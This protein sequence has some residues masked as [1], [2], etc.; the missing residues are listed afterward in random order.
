MPAG[1]NQTTSAILPFE[2]PAMERVLQPIE[3]ASGLPNAAYSNANFAAFER[4]KVLAR[5]WTCIGFGKDIPM[6]GDARPVN[7]M[8]L[9]LLMVRRRD[10]TI[11][12]FH[13][14]CSHRGAVL[15][16]ATRNAQSTFRCP[17]HAW[18][19]DL[20]GKL[21]ATPNIGGPKEHNCDGFDK[22]KHGLKE[23][24]TAL[25]WDLVFINL[26]G[27]AIAFDEFNSKLRARWGDYDMSLIRHCGADSSLQLTVNCNWKLAVE[28]YCEAYHL[29]VI[30]PGLNSYS[31]LEDHYNIN[32]EGAFAGQGSTAYTP[33]LVENGPD[34]PHF[35]G[36]PEKW[37]RAAEYA[38]LF[39]NVLL[40]IH[41][42]HYFAILLEPVAVDRTIE[43][44]EIYYVGDEAKSDSYAVTRAANLA[45]WKTV[46]DE[47]IGVVESMQRGRQ[48]PGFTGGAFSP[49]MDPPTHCFHKWLARA[50]L[51][52]IESAM[53][54]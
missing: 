8:G 54:G 3:T 42:D 16:D 5:T 34:L 17:Y 44:L 39:P 12:V 26:S 2:A 4:D 46:F 37:A 1:S 7:L 52:A 27:D 36:L 41:Q 30:H 38:A 45:T 19:Y 20:E 49:R 10:N 48:S 53:P 15:V 11:A 28:N 32:E 51:S 14:V 22:S 18:V 21:I 50:A 31:R 40:G 35:P 9:P 33:L 47:D 25:F 24:R 23:I 13:N 29:P 6:P 43:R